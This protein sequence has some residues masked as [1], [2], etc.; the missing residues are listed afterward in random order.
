MARALAFR[1]DIPGS[2]V[3]IASP[4]WSPTVKTGFS[5]VIGSWKIIPTCE[6]RILRSS[7]GPRPSTSRPASWTDPDTRAVSGSS[8]TTDSMLM[9]L[10]DPDSPTMPSVLPCVTVRSIPRTAGC[11]SCGVPKSMARSRM[12]SSGAPPAA[13]GPATPPAPGLPA[14]TPTVPACARPAGPAPRRR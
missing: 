12:A 3:R 9:L 4:T 2:C 8:D 10:P 6:P 7:R 14:V 5:E 13:A 1:R 11:G